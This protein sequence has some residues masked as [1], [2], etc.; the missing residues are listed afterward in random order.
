MTPRTIALALALW[1]AGA[2]GAL[3]DPLEGLW[4]SAP[5]DNGNT[6]LIEVAPCGDALCGTLTRAFGPDGAEIASD[7]VGRQIISETRPRGDGTYRGKVW[8]PDRDQTYNSRLTL[9]G[10][11]LQVEGCVLGICRNGGTWQRQ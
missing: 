8:A 11:V 7:R 10:D 2:A 1:A 9:E 5:D 6:G 3:A 4:R